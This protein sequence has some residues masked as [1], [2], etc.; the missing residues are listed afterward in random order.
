M[1]AKRISLIALLALLISA[2]GRKESRPVR[3]ER[4]VFGRSIETEG[5]KPLGIAISDGK[6]WLSDPDHKRVVQVDGRGR[7]VASLPGLER[8]MHMAARAGKMFIPEYTSDSLRVYENGRLTH[9]RAVAQV[10]ALAGIAVMDD[11]LVMV[12]FYN[13][14]ILVQSPRGSFSIGTEGHDSGELYYPTDV[15]IHEGRIYVADAYNNCVQVF[16]LLGNYKRMIGRDDSIR[17]AAGLKVSGQ[18]LF[19][20]DFEGNRV[21]VYDL[22]GNRIQTLTRGFQS[23]TDIERAG[24]TLY[25]TNYAAGSLTLYYRQAGSGEPKPEKAP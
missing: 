7:I 11:T 17:V 12:D 4:W 15:D 3:N 9:Q 16:D 18:D 13:H 22:E 14:R 2:C 19:I 20:T 24:D 8:P 10:D 5:V 1:N 25:V 21:L 6:L 23:P